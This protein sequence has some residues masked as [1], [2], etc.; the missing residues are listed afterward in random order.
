MAQEDHHIPDIAATFASMMLRSLPSRLQY[1]EIAF[2]KT[3]SV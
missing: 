3:H 1:M 2:G